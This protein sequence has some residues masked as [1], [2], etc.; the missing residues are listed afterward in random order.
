MHWLTT[1]FLILVILTT[2]CRL[3]LARRQIRHVTENRAVVPQPFDVEIGLDD[4]QK[5]ADYSA[6]RTKLGGFDT[7]LDA[8]LLVIW[9]LGGG[10][11]AVDGLWRSLDLGGIWLGVAT[12]F[13]VFLIGGL[14]GLP[15]SIYRTFGVEAR[16]GFNKTTPGL[17]IADLIKGLILAAV[18]GAPLLLAILWIMDK[19]GDLWWLYA[20]IV[21]AGFS[22]TLSWAYPAFIA[23]W[24]NH[25]PVF[26]TFI[27][28]VLSIFG[29]G[30]YNIFLVLTLFGNFLASTLLF[31]RFR[32]W[33]VYSLIFAFSSYTWIHLGVHPVLS[34]IW[35]YP[36]FFYFL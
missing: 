12:I 28:V 30:F 19:T 11:A 14:I 22:L 21:W 4:H 1:L 7:L 17:F 6:T 13:S 32:Y 26:T 29:V 24:F 31:R 10:L 25:Q 3:W 36:L 8:V 15:L 27:S 35:I 33:P 5:A 34:Q 9:T 23:P 20:W 18:L 2:G 16:F